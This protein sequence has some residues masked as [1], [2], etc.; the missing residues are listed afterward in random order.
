MN[1]PYTKPGVHTDDLEKFIF[2]GERRKWE[3]CIA[4]LFVVLGAVGLYFITQSS[5][6]T[7]SS[8]RSPIY[9]NQ[10]DANQVP[11]S[12]SA[13]EIGVNSSEIPQQLYIK[14]NME[15]H[16]AIRFTIDSFDKNAS[17]TLHMGNGEVKKIRKKTSKY[18]Y[19]QSGNYTVKLEVSYE[20]KTRQLA[21]ET[22]QIMEAIA[23]APTASLDF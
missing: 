3:R 16:E 5:Q 19:P 12:N 8:L 6:P 9:E 15:A 20:G 23:V 4:F 11:V 18:I 13:H 21:K 14:G 10:Q 17:Y 1:K 22:I 2:E 7:P